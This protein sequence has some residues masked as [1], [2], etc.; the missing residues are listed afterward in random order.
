MTT[1]EGVTTVKTR[2]IASI[3]LAGLAFAMPAAANAAPA[4]PVLLAMAS[5]AGEN[6]GADVQRRVAE[7]TAHYREHANHKGNCKDCADC[8]DCADCDGAAK[9]VSANA[10]RAGIC[11]PTT[12]AKAA[13]A[14]A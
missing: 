4:G 13:K 1:N 10:E 3:I 6:A 14:G 2:H 8:A 12:H 7:K 11:D 9:K 5:F